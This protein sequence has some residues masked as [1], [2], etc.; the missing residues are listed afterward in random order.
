MKSMSKFYITN[1]NSK[2]SPS[3]L[4]LG[5]AAGRRKKLKK[6]TWSLIS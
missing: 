5:R 6:S 3:S 4:P 2:F 1:V